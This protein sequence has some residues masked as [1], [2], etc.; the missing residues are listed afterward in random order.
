MNEGM[1]SLINHIAKNSMAG[2]VK[3]L[4][5]LRYFFSL[6]SQRSESNV[7]NEKESCNFHLNF[8]FLLRILSIDIYIQQSYLMIVTGLPPESYYSLNCLKKVK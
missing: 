5:F 2:L 1:D 6:F 7:M 4:S 3:I 8:K